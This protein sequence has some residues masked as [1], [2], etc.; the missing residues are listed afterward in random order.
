MTI[1]FYM[2]QRRERL[3]TLNQVTRVLI[4]IASHSEPL[5]KYIFCQF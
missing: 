1:V 2:I 5:I 4:T 3:Q